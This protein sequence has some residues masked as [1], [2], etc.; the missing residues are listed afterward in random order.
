MITKARDF[1]KNVHTGHFRRDGVTP[2]FTHLELVASNVES[3][4]LEDNVLYSEIVS[5]AWLHDSVEDGRTTLDVIEMEFGKIVSFLVERLTHREDMDYDEY[6]YLALQTESTRLIKI[7]DIL[8]NLSDSPTNKQVKKYTKALLILN[9]I[10]QKKELAVLCTNDDNFHKPY[11]FSALPKKG[12]IY[13]IRG[14][15]PPDC[16]GERNVYLLGINGTFSGGSEDGFKSHRFNT[17]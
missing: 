2:Y 1:A 16:N 11:R 8:A 9:T 13:F 10:S 15:R 3:M 7:A 6:I 5:A 12:S 17:L 4:L 14:F